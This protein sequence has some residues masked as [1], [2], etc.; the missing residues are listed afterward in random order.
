MKITTAIYQYSTPWAIFTFR[1]LWPIITTTTT[2]IT[3]KT[4]IRTISTTTAF[5]GCEMEMFSVN[6]SP[7]SCQ[8]IYLWGF[9]LSKNVKYHGHL[10]VSWRRDT[11]KKRGKRTFWRVETKILFPWT[12]PK[13]ICVAKNTWNTSTRYFF[14]GVK[15]MLK[16][17]YHADVIHSIRHTW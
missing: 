7:L 3:S 16:M 8:K 5:F 15:Y 4:T 1:F 6:D 11:L 13:M 17:K 10:I 14:F 9:L 12:S 2:W